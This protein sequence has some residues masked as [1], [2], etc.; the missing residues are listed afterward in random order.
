MSDLAN[1]CEY[2]TV[3]K[4][5][6]AVLDSEK[7][8]AKRQ[9]GCQNDEKL[10]C[11]YLC[12][13][14]S[15]CAISC[16]FLGKPSAETVTVEAPKAELENSFEAGTDAQSTSEAVPVVWCCGTEMS[17]AKTK[18]SVDKWQGSHSRLDSVLPVIVYVCSR[19]G[20]VEFKATEVDKTGLV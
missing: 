11:C 9:A 18:L 5:C 3:E 7:A 14:K 16:N 15:V 10:S 2:L 1:C 8:K 20:K 19:C 17:W 12:S 13:F 4:Q 6:S